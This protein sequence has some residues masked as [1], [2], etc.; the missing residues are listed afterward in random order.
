VATGFWL[1]GRQGEESRRVAYLPALAV[2]AC[3]AGMHLLLDLTNDAGVKLLWPFSA[4]WFAWDLAREVDP[5]LLVILLAGLL[6]PV[7]FNLVGEEIGARGRKRPGARGAV[8]ALILAAAYVGGRAVTHQRADALL[9][10]HVYQQEA[11][12]RTAAFPTVS[13][14]LWRGVVETETAMHEVDV[15]LASGTE[16]DPR[17]AQSQ[18]K[19][20]NSQAL[21]RAVASE[22][23]LEFLAFA[24]FPLARV[25]P[26][27]DGFEVRIR[28]RREA[29]A[30]PGAAEI[31]AVITLNAREEVTHSDLRFESG[32]RP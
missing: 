4:R 2:C 20:E 14:L 29:A 9:N 13:P 1:W 25:Q 31:I 18:F 7:L 16:F 22:A 8:A 23:A 27:Q 26:T 5:G 17:T 28:D 6:L 15:S 3:A 12:I 21:Q 24:R 30:A 10:S 19:P 11:P 32:T